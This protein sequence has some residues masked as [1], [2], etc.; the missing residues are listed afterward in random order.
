MYC[1]IKLK[2][3]KDHYLKI[4]FRRFGLSWLSAKSLQSLTFVWII[5]VWDI[6][7]FVDE[8]QVRSYT[9]K[10]CACRFYQYYRFEHKALYYR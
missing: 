2:Q 6:Q 8:W 5:L 3:K 4:D 10:I 9:K 7:K 1:K